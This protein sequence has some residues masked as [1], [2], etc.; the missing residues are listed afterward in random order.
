VPEFGSLD[1][2]VEFFETHDM[3]EYW[4]EVPEVHFDIDIK[5][6][7][8]IFTLD[9]D[10]AERVSAIARARRIPPGALIREWLR[11][12]IAEETGAK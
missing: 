5:R 6:R 1:E 11:E 3:G 7:T 4:N 12:K 10:L 8:H 2:L 9:E